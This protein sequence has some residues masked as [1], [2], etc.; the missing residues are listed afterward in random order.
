MSITE[1]RTN[2]DNERESDFLNPS[3]EPATV[4][5]LTDPETDNFTVKLVHYLDNPRGYYECKKEDCPYCKEGIPRSRRFWVEVWHKESK[6]NKILCQ[7]GR[8]GNILREFHIDFKAE[9]KQLNREIKGLE[10]RMLSIKNTG[11]TRN[12]TWK[13]VPVALSEE[14]FKKNLQNVKPIFDIPRIAAKTLKTA[15]PETEE[16]TFEEQNDEEFSF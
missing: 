16:L 1:F 6:K 11:S 3:A 8:L 12:P 10:G 7:G 9:D 4:Y 13:I 2:Q 14:Y 15:I 5:F